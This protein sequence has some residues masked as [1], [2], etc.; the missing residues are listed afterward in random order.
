[1]PVALRL[2][3]DV[4]HFPRRQELA[5]LDVDGF[6]RARDVLDEVGLATQEGRRLQYVDDRRDFVQ[7]RVFVYVG[8]HRDANLL[9][10]FG[11]DAQAC[12]ESRAAET[13]ARGA[14]G[15]VETGFEDEG[16][17]EFCGDFLELSRRVE[18]QLFRLDHARAGNQE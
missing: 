10:Y 8:E 12:F 11:E 15:L 5:F 4:L 9:F 7:R 1:L 17:A 3:G 6:S 14:V 16:N 13:R 2:G 18:L